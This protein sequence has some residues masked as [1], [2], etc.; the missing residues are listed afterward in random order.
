MTTSRIQ[1]FLFLV[2]CGIV[3]IPLRAADCSTPDLTLAY[4]Q[5]AN[6]AN[7][8]GDI[9]FHLEIGVDGAP[10]IINTEWK[11][12]PKID[13]PALLAVAAKS[14]ALSTRYPLECVGQALDLE[15][16]YRKKRPIGS[17][18]PGISERLGPHH[19]QVTTNEW[20]TDQGAG[21]ATLSKRSFWWRL[22]HR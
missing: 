22:F 2:T 19:F 15:L 9:L 13:P 5:A 7:M 21:P 14:V 16:S 11:A 18:D 6:M 8:W 20:A 17:L 4:P 12:N 3:A 1:S 10:A